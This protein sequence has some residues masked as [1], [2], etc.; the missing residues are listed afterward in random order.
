M[1]NTG[2][3]FELRRLGPEGCESLIA[4]ATPSGIRMSPRKP[5][6]RQTVRP[7]SPSAVHPLGSRAKRGQSRQRS[8]NRRSFPGPCIVVPSRVCRWAYPARLHRRSMAKKKP[9]MSPRGFVTMARRGELP[10]TIHA[11]ATPSGGISRMLEHDERRLLT[12]RMRA[13]CRAFSQ[14]EGTSMPALK[15][16]GR[17]RLRDH[18]RT[19]TPWTKRHPLQPPRERTAPESQCTTAARARAG[20]TR[21]H[22]ALTLACRA[23]PWHEWGSTASRT[24]VR[25]PQGQELHYFTPRR[26]YLHLRLLRERDGPGTPAH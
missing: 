15:V 22:Q 7:D 20:T 26:P 8:S 6:S 23:L 18:E 10:A 2:A 12:S 4:A 11:Q 19:K 17:G 9:G 24:S 3:V 1:G 16:T 13:S 21:T 14:L 5:R 25:P